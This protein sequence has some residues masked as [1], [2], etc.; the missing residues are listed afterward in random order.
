MVIMLLMGI[1]ALV[2]TVRAVAMEAA[3]VVA[4][5]VVCVALEWLEGEEF[6]EDED[7]L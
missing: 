5:I 2:V 1:L 4:F 3:G 6:W 7:D